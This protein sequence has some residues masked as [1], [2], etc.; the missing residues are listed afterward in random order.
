MQQLQVHNLRNTVKIVDLDKDDLNDAKADA[1]STPQHVVDQ[2][3]SCTI[4]KYANRQ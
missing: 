3:P 1:V 4:V 2:P